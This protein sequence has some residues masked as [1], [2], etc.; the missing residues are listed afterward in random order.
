MTD[1]AIYRFMLA[2]QT[3]YGVP[4]KMKDIITA[5]SVAINHRSSVFYAL[6]RLQDKGLVR[7][8]RPACYARRY[9]AVEE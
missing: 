7:E 4:P 1:E 3:R 8:I 9:L 2:Y 5:T 6:R